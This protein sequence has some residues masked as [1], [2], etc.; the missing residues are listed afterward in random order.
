MAQKA[1]SL[2]HTKWLCKYHIV[3][4]P[5]YRRKVIYNEL[6]KDVGGDPQEVVRI[7]GD[8]GDR[9]ASDARPRPHAGGDPAEVQR[10]E[11][12]GVSEG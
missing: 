4:T 10:V 11:R 3:C 5:K 6:R 7:Q 2:S 12:D 8:R 1:Y 9:G